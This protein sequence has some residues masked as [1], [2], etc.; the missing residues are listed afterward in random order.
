MKTDP[1]YPWINTVKGLPNTIKHGMALLGV[2]EAI[3]KGSNKTILEWRDALNGAAP[4][5]KPIISGYSDD[6][7]PWCGLFTAFVCWL[8]LK[9][10]S[11]VVKTPLWAKSWANYGISVAKRIKGKL[12]NQN[13]LVPSLGDILVFERNGGGHVG[14]YIAEDQ[15]AFHVLG[16]NQSDKV[17]ITR[18]AK[19]RCIAVRRPPY[20]TTP[21]GVRPYHVASSGGLSKNEA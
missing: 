12:V 14:F 15:T 8:R 6:S 19:D 3:G 2:T 11:E 5:G 21:T 16:G 9:N 4:E 18:I 10:I 20:V 1:K 7:I 17:C 13:G